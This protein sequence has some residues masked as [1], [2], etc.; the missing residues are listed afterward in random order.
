MGEETGACGVGSALVT[1]AAAARTVDAAVLVLHGGSVDGLGAPR[2]WNL[3]AA[4]MR[5]F[6]RG[7]ERATAGGEVFVGEVRYRH[8][9]WNGDREDAARDARRAVD[10]LGRRV[11]EVPVVLV[12]HSMG[13]RAALRAAGHPM[14]RS[15]VAL[16]PWCPEHE[17]VAQLRGRRLVLVHGDRDRTTDPR[18]SWQFAARAAEAGALPSTVVMRGGDHPMLRRAGDWHRLTVSLVTGLLGRTPLPPVVAERFSGGT[19]GPDPSEW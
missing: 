3:A 4:R 17:P 5:P 18:A 2:R 7:I 12:G 19:A 6:T 11:G 13:G 10:E 1:R 8:R 14:V 9:G 16:A 15:V